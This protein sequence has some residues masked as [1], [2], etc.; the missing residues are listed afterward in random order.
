MYAQ[1]SNLDRDK[2]VIGL[3]ICD[4]FKSSKWISRHEQNTYMQ[5]AVT[6]YSDN[7]ASN[8]CVLRF[9]EL[10]DEEKAITWGDLDYAQKTDTR[11][12]HL[13]IRKEIRGL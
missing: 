2:V 6:C 1:S 12:M 3:N 5:G 13:N 9:N 8:C 7:Y 10:L 4:A 11:R